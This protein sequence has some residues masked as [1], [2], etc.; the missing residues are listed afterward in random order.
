MVLVPEVTPINPI[1]GTPDWLIK[2]LEMVW[3]RPSKLPLNATA[4]LPMGLKPLRLFQ[5]EVLVASM[6]E[7]R[8]KFPARRPF[9]PCKSTA[10]T[11]PT[12]PKSLITK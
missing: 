11:L 2:R 1:L 8:A 7:P 6:F 4:L 10:L 5:V 9:I 12:D 3:P